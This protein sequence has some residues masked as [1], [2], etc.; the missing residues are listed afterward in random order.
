MSDFLT[1]LANVDL[2]IGGGPNEN[3]VD[4]INRLSSNGYWQQCADFIISNIESATTQDQIAALTNKAA[5]YACCGSIE[6]ALKQTY[7]IYI[8]IYFFSP[9]MN[10]VT[11]SEV[12]KMSNFLR[13][14]VKVYIT[15]LGGQIKSLILKRKIAQC[16]CLAVLRY[17]PQNWPTIFDEIISLFKDCGGKSKLPLFLYVVYEIRAPVSDTNL[18]LVNLLDI[19]LDLLFELDCIAFD[20]TLN[21]TEEQFKRTS[22][23]KDAMRISCLPTIIEMLTSVLV[24]LLTFLYKL[25]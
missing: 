25:A 21:L 2:S 22:D 17:Y 13:N 8:S 16:V 15:C 10:A 4:M 9:A 11:P 12:Q 1:D 14:W 20:R 7:V 19:F 6:N 5:F 18:V 23:V 24:S 3:I